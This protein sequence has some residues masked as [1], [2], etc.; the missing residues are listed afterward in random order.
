MIIKKAISY[1]GIDTPKT[2]EE[3]K[4]EMLGLK[5]AIKIAEE[6]ISRY[7]QVFAIMEMTQKQMDG[8][9]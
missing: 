5:N 9:K 2:V 1:A 4:V 7:E 3:I 6:L 8:Y